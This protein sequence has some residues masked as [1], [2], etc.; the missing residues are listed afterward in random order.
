M[1]VRCMKLGFFERVY[2][3]VKQIP[4]GYVMTYSQIAK[5]LG[6]P[7]SARIVGWALHVNPDNTL[8]PCHRVVNS[9][10]MISSGFV[11]GGPQ[12][13]RQKLEAE[14]IQ[15]DEQGKINLKTYLFKISKDS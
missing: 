1:K 3:V 10:G 9:K 2:D 12:V 13:Q 14:G 6:S 15:F 4:K 7:R 8:I 11:I 5:V